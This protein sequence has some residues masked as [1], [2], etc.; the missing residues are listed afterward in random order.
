[1]LAARPTE[2]APFSNTGRDGHIP[3]R[4]T[5]R[6]EPSPFPNLRLPQEGRVRRMAV[7]QL[8]VSPVGRTLSASEQQGPHVKLVW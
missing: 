8:A 3:A 5:Q 2:R 7:S 1:M 4:M 6:T